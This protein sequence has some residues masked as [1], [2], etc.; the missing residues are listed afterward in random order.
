[1]TV[2]GSTR[3]L[4]QH[5][6]RSLGDDFIEPPSIIS[7]IG[8]DDD[9]DGTEDFQLKAAPSKR[10]A[11]GGGRQSRIGRKTNP[12]V[13]QID[14]DDSME[15][16]SI[17][18]TTGKNNNNRKYVGQESEEKGYFRHLLAGK[19]NIQVLVDQ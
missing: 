19:T 16:S 8:N 17:R 6:Q 18:M 10:R 11:R 15:I 3:S 12:T 1:M 7:T 5:V 13:N 14:D 2:N 9:D 4:R